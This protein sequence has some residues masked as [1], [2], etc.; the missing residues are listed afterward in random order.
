MKVLKDIVAL[1]GFCLVLGLSVRQ[2]WFMT[3][4]KNK[5]V[6]AI[7]AYAVLTVLLALVRP[8]DRD[9]EIL[10]VTYNLRFL[11]FFLYGWL[12]TF[13]FPVKPQ[14]SAA[15]KIVL[16]SS[17][18]V[19]GFGLIQ[20]WFLPNN[21]LT[22][23]GFTKENGVFPAFF[24]DDKPNLE[25]VMSTVR[26]PN[27]LGSYLIIIAS[28]IGA[29]FAR[30]KRDGRM[31]WL[32][33]L[34]V[35]LLCLFLTFSRSALLGL[36]IAGGILVVLLGKE[37]VKVTSAQLRYGLAGAVVLVIALLGGLYTA[38]NTYIVQNVIFHADQSTTQED[39]NQLRVRFA[40]ESLQTVANHPLG[41]GPG[42]AGLASIKN[43]VQG[44][45]LNENYYLQIASEVGILGLLL[46]IAILLLVARALY[47]A[48]IS[49]TTLA[50]LASFAGLA[51]TN[52]L[53]HIWSN[54]AVAYT[55]W[56]LASLIM[57]SRKKVQH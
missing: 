1:F 22:P 17:S 18:V 28:L 41:Q 50:L 8:T 32:G 57:T 6:I 12:L 31:F 2:P 54:E 35:T 26:D 25:R 3:W 42:T 33:L 38:R 36:V 24:I 27:S 55:W 16:V 29:K 7:I 46:F 10:G 56:G 49:P 37:R 34:L 53:V 51:L 20:Y 30:V 13:W 14:L 19:V 11:M 43:N 47:R 5:L 45:K 44:T 15:T 52:L 21:A 4:L 9:A 40:K 48:P 39:P 23:L